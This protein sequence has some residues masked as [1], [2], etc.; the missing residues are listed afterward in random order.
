MSTASID[1]RAEARLRQRAK[2]QG[3]QLRRWRG[4]GRGYGLCDP[5][6]GDAIVGLWDEGYTLDDIEEALRESCLAPPYG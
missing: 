1:A 5:N 2:A 6:S 3:Y 4:P